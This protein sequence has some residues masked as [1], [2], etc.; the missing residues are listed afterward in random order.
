MHGLKSSSGRLLVLKG[1][2]SICGFART[3]SVAAVSVA[4]V[5]CVIKSLSSNNLRIR[6]IEFVDGA[7]V[8]VAGTP[9]NR[10]SVDGSVSPSVDGKGL[11]STIARVIY[12]TQAWLRQYLMGISCDSVCLEGV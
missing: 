4:S 6:F 11:M 3:R 8:I 12:V 5:G 10:L 2:D 7:F 1:I 9:A